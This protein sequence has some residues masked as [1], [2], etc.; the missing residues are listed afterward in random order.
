MPYFISAPIELQVQQILHLHINSR[1]QFNIQDL[2]D[3]MR[4]YEADDLME[5]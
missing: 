1:R 2:M 3:S 4:L 5:T